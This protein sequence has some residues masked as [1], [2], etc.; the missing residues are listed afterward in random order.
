MEAAN[1]LLVGAAVATQAGI[2]YEVGVATDDAA[3][4][5]DEDDPEKK[6]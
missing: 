4:V 5:V 3:V 2:A 6:E 1:R